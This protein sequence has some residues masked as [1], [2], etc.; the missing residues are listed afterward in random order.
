[1]FRGGRKE[2][3]HPTRIRLVLP[4]T[5][6]KYPDTDTQAGAPRQE[7]WVQVEPF[8]RDFECVLIGVKSLFGVPTGLPTL[9]IGSY[10]AFSIRVPGDLG[11][12]LIDCHMSITINR[13][14]HEYYY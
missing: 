6:T 12:A 1:M 5:K 4:G 2:F 10:T 14:P 9:I 13:L 3:V 8:R 7:P 11:M